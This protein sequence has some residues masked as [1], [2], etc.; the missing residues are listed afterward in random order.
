MSKFWF[1]ALQVYCGLNCFMAGYAFS[2]EGYSHTRKERIIKALICVVML[3]IGS[4][5]LLWDLM[6]PLIIKVY[7]RTWINSGVLT[8]KTWYK[9]E[10]KKEPVTIGGATLKAMLSRRMITHM[11]IFWHDWWLTFIHKHLDLKREEHFQEWGC[12]PKW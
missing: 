12:N 2:E 6:V 3:F 1:I 5:L 8:L 10:Y 11:P 7:K 9:Y 4:L